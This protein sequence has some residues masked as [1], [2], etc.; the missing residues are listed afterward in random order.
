MQNPELNNEPFFTEGELEV[1]SA[2]G[3]KTTVYGYAALF[4]TR[5]RTLTTKKGAKF[6]EEILP[7]AFDNTDFSD[8]VCFFNHEGR[9]F[10]AAQ[11]N[12]RYGVDQRG[13][14]YEYDHDPA[15]PV[16]VSALRRIQR[17]D[18]KG[19]SF[20]FP[21][22]LSDCYTIIRAEGDLPLRQIRRFPTVAEFGPVITP[23]YRGTT[24][25][26]RSVG[27]DDVE[28]VPSESESRDMGGAYDADTD[29]TPAQKE[30]GNYKKGKVRVHGME[31]SIENP[32]G[33]VRSGVD[34]DGKAWESEMFAHYGYILGSK[35]GDGDNLDVF[36]TDDAESARLVFV[37][38]QIWPDGSFDEHKC[39]IGPNRMEQAKQLYLSHYSE[40]WTGCGAICSVPIACFR[41]WAL[42]G[43]IKKESLMYEVGG[44]DKGRH[45]SAAKRELIEQRK[46]QVRAT[47][48]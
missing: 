15:D 46:L 24:T 27:I 5:S 26:A 16:H 25:S 47:L 40:G 48:M 17:R 20:Q 38:D 42:D 43:T 4:N 37:V 21:P 12:L 8:A 23:A 14:W 9:D 36:L 45:R 30:A 31:M 29:P 34:K 44:T 39:L 7:G 11:P 3:G 33:S 18:A 22:L 19:S 28:I 13:L 10:L 35:A 6:V 2:E 32:K 1:R 41:A